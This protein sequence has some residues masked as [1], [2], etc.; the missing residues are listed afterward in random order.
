[1]AHKRW[2]WHGYHTVSAHKLVFWTI[3]WLPKVVHP[4]IAAVTALIFF[5]L[6]KKER[7]A[8]RAN[9]DHVQRRRPLAAWW[10][11]YKVFYSFCDFVV[12]YCYVPKADD[13]ALK[14]MLSE[15]DSGAATI[16][17]CLAGGNGLVVWTAHLGNWEFASRLL[18][19]Y[20]R[21]VHVARVV[22]RDNPAEMMLRGMM[23]N[24]RL[25]P[26]QLNDNPLASI[27]L[28]SALRNNDIVAMQG[29]RVYQDFSA[30]ARFFDAEARFPLGPFLLAYIA[31][32]PLL[33][34]V[35]VRDG[36]LR[37]HTVLGSP[38][39]IPHTGERD[40]DLRAGLLRAVEFLER[41]VR[42]HP[43]QWMNFYEFW[44]AERSR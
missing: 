7:R 1:M 38:I 4:P 30:P 14:S 12:S 25:K 17:E 24:E 36:W 33:P 41:T 42:A 37:Y 44:P 6:L 13:G 23:T 21:T 40:A 19:M 43:N 5:V 26:V 28:L 22:E 31:G 39:A 20:G 9:L 11:V 15:P 29:D 35:V 2:Y 32:A 8:V 16:R 3:P 27:E 18:E 34:G 10:R